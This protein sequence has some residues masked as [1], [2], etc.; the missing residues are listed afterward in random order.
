VL[1]KELSS[2]GLVNLAFHK[3]E[4]HI[5]YS[6]I[7]DLF[8]FFEQITFCLIPIFAPT[9][10]SNMEANKS[11]SKTTDGFLIVP[12]EILESIEKNQVEILNLLK[13]KENVNSET[14]NYVDEKKAIEIIGK[15]AT[16]FWQMRKSGGLNYTKVGAKVYYSIN[17]IKKLIENGTNQ[18]K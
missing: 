10:Q 2:S 17:E 5:F 1:I 6:K 14:L 13:G 12:H 3:K 8:I 4:S 18:I 9:K 15:K 7:S 16:W 11:K